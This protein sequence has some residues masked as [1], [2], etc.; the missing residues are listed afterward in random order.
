MLA[1]DTHL[2]CWDRALFDYAWLEGTDL[3]YRFTP[4]DIDGGSGIRAIF[5]EADRRSEQAPAEAEWALS[6][7]GGEPAVVA[8]VAHAPLGE[9]TRARTELQRLSGV[10]GVTG[11]RRLLQDEPAAFFSDRRFLADL[12]AVGAAG[13][14]FDACVRSHQLREL[15]GVARSAPDTLIVLDHL[16]K[17]AVGRPTGAVRGEWADGIHELAACDNVVVKI[18]GMLPPTGTVEAVRPWVVAALEAFGPDRAVV[19]SDWPVSR[20]ADMPYRRWFEF[21][22]TEC[23]LS[24]DEA[25]RV[26]RRNAERIYRVAP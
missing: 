26:G 9:G 7:T 15:A 21:V 18:S 12:R 10:E 8:A 5:M 6:L 3:P 22:L 20:R 19:G 11:I 16:G 2:H 24:A 13:M 4:D 23:G 14:V 25:D 1:I 17:P